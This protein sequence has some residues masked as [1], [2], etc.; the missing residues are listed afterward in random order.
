MSPAMQYY[1][2]G[3]LT[4]TPKK[5]TTYFSSSRTRRSNPCES[6]CGYSMNQQKFS[7]PL[8]MYKT[9]WKSSNSF[10]TSCD[11]RTHGA[12]DNSE[13]ITNWVDCLQKTK[14]SPLSEDFNRTRRLN[15]IP[16]MSETQS[17]IY[18]QRTKTFLK[19]KVIKVKHTLLSE[20]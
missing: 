1:T 6:E 4:T 14:D 8:S 7:L 19:G 10:E 11:I 20:R 5:K 2:E 9:D 16:N 12:E 18:Q 17:K 15:N 3:H 13:S